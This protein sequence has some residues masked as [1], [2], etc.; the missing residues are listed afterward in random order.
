MWTSFARHSLYILHCPVSHARAYAHSPLDGAKSSRHMKDCI[1]L[2]VRLTT[3]SR[4]T[5]HLWILLGWI[6]RCELVLQ[7][8]NVGS[9]Y[10]SYPN[11]GLSRNFETITISV[12]ETT[13][14]LQKAFATRS[15]SKILAVWEAAYKTCT[16]GREGSGCKL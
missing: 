6:Q 1:G 13:F 15:S 14:E 2:S 8:W 11:K 4:I 5:G 7:D 9:E 3:S 16:Y 10:E 12:C